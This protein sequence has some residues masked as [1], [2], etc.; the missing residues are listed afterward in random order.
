M[1]KSF[2]ILQLFWVDLHLVPSTKDANATVDTGKGR[3]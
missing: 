3:P 2:D 1:Q